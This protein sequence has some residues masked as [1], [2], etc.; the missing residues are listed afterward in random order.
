MTSIQNNCL[1]IVSDVYHA[2]SISVLKTETFTSLLNLYLNVKLTQFWLRHKK[3]GMKNLIKN[4][5]LKICSKLQRRRHHQQQQL[6]QTEEEIRIQWAKMWLK[7]KHQK[8]LSAFKMLLSRWKQWW[9]AEKSEWK[10]LEIRE[11]RHAAVKQH[12]ALHK[13]ESTVIIQIRTDRIE[14]TAFLNQ[15]WV[16]DVEFSVC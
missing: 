2:T 1:W 10:L 9:K 7:N 4:A 15:T 3:S 12:A 16:S 8:S 5:C 6:M 13:T 14:L 11:L